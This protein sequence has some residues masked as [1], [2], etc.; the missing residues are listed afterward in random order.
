MSEYSRKAFY[1]DKAV[2]ASYSERRFS[3]S[4]GKR[5]HEATL[6]ALAAALERIPQAKT[7]LDMPCGTGRFAELISERG[8][9]SVGA[10]IS[11]EMLEVIADEL[12]RQDWN[13]SLVRCDGER[14]PFK[15]AA[16]D[17]V[18]C[19][20]FLNLVP[21]AVRSG[22]LAEMRRVSNEWLVVQ[23]HHLKSRS[24]LV[25]F[26]LLLRKIFGRDVSKY[27]L[28]RQILMAGWREIAQVPVERARHYVGVYR[29]QR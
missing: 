20:R 26:K 14:L 24:P 9:R 15:D 23:S 17:C 3:G 11:M 16:F 10:D 25:R 22:I 12:R 6:K 7:F 19:V 2:A 8:Y 29:K 27:E 1:Q 18:V 28:Q 5:E 4:K 13:L 21:S